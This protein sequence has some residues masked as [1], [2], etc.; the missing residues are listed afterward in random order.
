MVIGTVRGR[1]KRGWEVERAID[2]PVESRRSIGAV[3][4]PGRSG[5][6]LGIRTKFAQS[7]FELFEQ[8]GKDA[9]EQAVKDQVSNPDT[10][11]E[12]VDKYLLKL[13]PKGENQQLD[14]P[15]QKAIIT[16]DVNTS[17]RSTPVVI[18][19]PIRGAIEKTT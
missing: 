18:D 2:E 17:D 15:S 6:N 4:K 5:R 12:F 11:L 3:G 19:Q 10:V 9:L 1:I 14:A 13:I 16:I 7:L 8:Y